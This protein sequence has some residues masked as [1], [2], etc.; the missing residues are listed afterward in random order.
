MDLRTGFKTRSVLALPITLPASDRCIGVLEGLNKQVGSFTE[1]DTAMLQVFA[2]VAG[3]VLHGWHMHSLREARDEREAALRELTLDVIAHTEL[4][5]I[6]ARLLSL[7]G[8]TLLHCEHCS[9]LT[10]EAGELCLKDEAFCTITRASTGRGISALVVAGQT[11]NL[12]DARAHPR[13]DA[14]VDAGGGRCGS[15]LAAPISDPRTGEVLAVVQAHNKLPSELEPYSDGE[16]APAFSEEDEQLLRS[17][18]AAVTKALS[19]RS[20]SSAQHEEEVRRANAIFDLSQEVCAQPDVPAM[21]RL[22]RRRGP[23]LFGCERC[24][25]FVLDADA[26]ELFTQGMPE[27]GA[28]GEVRHN[29]A[30]TLGLTGHVASCGE[31]LNLREA[32]A[33][34][35]F[36]AEVDWQGGYRTRTF[37]C[38]PLVSGGAPPARPAPPAAH[39][40]RTLRSPPRRRISFPLGHNRPADS[41]I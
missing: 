6:C 13:F 28:G 22:V 41:V 8:P 34:A 39:L 20:S 36:A 29:Y 17:V 14:A 2:S 27:G 37:F 15:F 32:Y 3:L 16:A 12:A 38:T 26:R 35:R 11:V 23:R 18:V 40:L 30:S 4:H 33:D 24:T 5:P 7:R 10:V 25:L 31:T 19:V 1:E 21:M 9:I